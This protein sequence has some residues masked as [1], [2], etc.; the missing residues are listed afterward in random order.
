VRY[1]ARQEKGIADRTVAPF[2]S[3]SRATTT[4]KKPT[5]PYYFG[6]SYTNITVKGNININSYGPSYSNINLS[7]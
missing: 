1:A 2:E 6:P 7:T 4:K 5:Y 3:I